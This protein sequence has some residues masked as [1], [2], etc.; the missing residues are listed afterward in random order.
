MLRLITLLLSLLFYHVSAQNMGRDT[1]L[2]DEV[3]I[4]KSRINLF[5]GAD[6]KV[7]IDSL[8]LL[9]YANTDLS[10]LLAKTA[11]VNIV[12]YGGSGSQASVSIR[13]GNSAH[14]TVLWNGIP[15]NSLTAGGADL[16]LINAGAFDQ[17]NI[18]Y[19]ASGSLY[20]SGTFGGA[21][22]LNN[23][24]SFEKKNDIDLYAG[25]S[26]WSNKRFRGSAKMSDSRFS[27]SG[28][29]FY[30]DG[31]NNF[32]YSDQLDFGNPTERLTHAENIDFG[33][34]HHLSIKLKN[35]EVNFGG[36]YQIKNHNIPGKMGIGPP[37][38]YQHQ[39]DSTLKIF[40]GWKVII[41]KVRFEFQSAWLSD[42]LRYTDKDP[43]DHSWKTYSEISSKRWLNT[44]NTRYYASNNLCFDMQLGYN[45]L[46]GEVTAY[47][48]NRKEEELA[49]SFAGQYVSR[50]LTLN[51]SFAKEWNSVTSPPV[52]Y[53]VG[54]SWYLIPKTIQ[55]KTKYGTH[56][57]RPVF[58]ERYWVPGGNPDLN[59]EE[60]SGYDLGI[61]LQKK[62]GQKQRLQASVNHY[63]SVNK[64][65]II[66]LPSGGYSKSENTNKVQS[67][68]FELDV[69][70]E[71]NMK[72]AKLQLSGKYAYNDTYYNND[73]LDNYKEELAYK[74]KHLI[75]G[76]VDYNSRKRWGVSVNNSFQTKMSTNEGTKMKAVALTDIWGRY[77]FT[78]D[79]LQL[80]VN[81]GIQNVLNKSYQ[82]IYAYPMPGRMYSIGINI[83]L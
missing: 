75:K 71:L 25:F 69:E 74:P 32:T 21:V 29:V 10:Y 36:W 3:K 18:V 17:I 67:S 31:K 54:M 81:A 73:T 78:I 51:V 42:F 63:L 76:I 77:N 70:W 37:V 53:N 44:F 11:L 28:Q 16:S 50:N 61:Y 13:G 30:Q 19:G 1:I 47:K 5:S 82:L 6:Y 68:G 56:Y 26:S 40:T 59:S 79:F 58:N 2:V 46:K 27:Y 45:A 66:W 22:E 38:S 12:N 83:K 48:M 34:I 55:I 39:K 57:R 8:Q 65:M 20:G 64:N 49:T 35:H 62:M 72:K 7:E 24:A 43:T 60:G 80:M 52:V 9:S 14:T 4:V 23:V 41:N 33:S 15:I